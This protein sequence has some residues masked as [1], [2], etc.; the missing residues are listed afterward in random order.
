MI[1]INQLTKEYPPSLQNFKLSILREYLQYKILQTIFKSSVSSK[2]C[3]MGGTALRIVYNNQR[4][5]EDLDFDNFGLTVDEFITLSSEVKKSLELEG[6]EV[7]VKNVFRQVFRCYIKI[8]R[9]LKDQGLSNLDDE[10]IVIQ[11]DTTPQNFEF[12]PETF[13]LDKFDV[14][15]NI[16]VTPVDILLSQKVAAFLNRKATKG[17]DLFDIVF[18]LQRDI[19]PNMQ[20]LNQKINLSS[21]EEVKSALM[22]KADELDLK[23]VASDVMPF[24]FNSEEADRI[25]S[26]TTYIDNKL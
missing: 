15:A 18:L 10:K 17:R 5:S 2:L 4:F 13:L 22:N 23:A 3:F 6:Y 14:F 25:Y 20:Y 11:I 16:S 12:Q 9:L 8:P 24:L 1:D 21:H 19:K 7:E 26:F